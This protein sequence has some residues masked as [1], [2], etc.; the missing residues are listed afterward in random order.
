MTACGDDGNKVADASVIDGTPGID[1]C[2]GHTC[3]SGTVMV[4]D[5][6][7][8]NL[9]LEHMKLDTQLQG[10]FKLPAG[11]TTQ[12]RIM[13]Y[14]MSAQTPNANPLPAPGVC[15]NLATTKGWPAFVGTP[16]TDIDV[17][18]LTIKGKN[19]AGRLVLSWKATTD[20]SGLV[21]AYLVYVKGAI[22]QTLPGSE[23]SV[24]MGAFSMSDTR[25]FQ[26]AARDAAGNVSGKT[27][28][29]V[30]IPKVAKL[31]QE[32]PR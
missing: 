23:L 6:E 14:F 1:A 3:G 20:N 11:V 29:L 26:V 4:T 21:D 16:H 22:S 7:G 18:T 32:V 24:D 5:P 28:A 27:F 12:T 8:G 13:A 19:A 25:S 17:G 9:V 2:V 31:S 15:T 10:F 30:V